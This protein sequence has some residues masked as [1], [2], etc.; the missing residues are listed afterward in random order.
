M[1]KPTK[2]T[3]DAMERAARLALE[4]SITL[5]QFADAMPPEAVL[6]LVGQELGRR[7]ADGPDEPEIE[8]ELADSPS[9]EERE[10]RRATIARAKAGLSPLV[11]PEDAAYED[12]VCTGWRVPLPAAA[13]QA[14]PVVT[15]EDARRVSRQQDAFD[16]WRLG[17]GR[18][19]FAGARP[20]PK[21]HRE[22]G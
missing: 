2:P 1:I 17:T 22:D 6:Y 21:I 9:A 11:S 7:A 18:R 5:E 19:P 8:L 3:L 14:H 4:G 20:L 15:P 12:E 10:R 13:L 16:E